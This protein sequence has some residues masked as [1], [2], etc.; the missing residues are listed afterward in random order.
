MTAEL[1][2]R[3]EALAYD[4]ASGAS[5]EEK[6]VSGILYC[7]L[8][9]LSSGRMN[10]LAQVILAFAER[11][12]GFPPKG[13]AVRGRVIEGDKVAGRIIDGDKIIRSRDKEE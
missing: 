13:D 7:T 8:G 1:A 2:R 3:V 9:A 10:A 12:T 4:L 6:Q 5:V 11:E